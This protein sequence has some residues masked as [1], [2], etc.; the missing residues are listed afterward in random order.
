MYVEAL[1]D[2]T[3]RDELFKDASRIAIWSG[4]Q[5]EELEEN[6]QPAILRILNER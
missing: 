1:S 5:V 4:R 3:E 6:F 2:Q